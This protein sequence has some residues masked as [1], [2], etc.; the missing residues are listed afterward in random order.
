MESDEN[1][2]FNKLR[3][4][5]MILKEEIAMNDIYRENHN[6]LL[7]KIDKN[8]LDYYKERISIQE[9]YEQ[10]N[11]SSDENHIKFIVTENP[12]KE[13]S[14]CYDP[15][16][17]LMFYFRDSNDLTLKLIDN[18]PKESYD[19]L[20]NFICNY[21]YE[22]IFSS[23]FLN[24]NLLTLI[25]L[26]LEKEID[27]LSNEKQFSTFLDSSTSFTAVLLKHLSRRDEIKLYLENI[28]KKV[29]VRT[30]G[31][32]SNQ[33]NE[34]FI[35]LDINN[36]KNFM[37][38]QKYDLPK[39]ENKI[40][41]L[42]EIL[43]INIKK[44]RLNMNFLKKKTEKEDNKDEELNNEEIKNNFYDE[45]T[46]ETFDELLFENE[47]DEIGMLIDED[48]ESKN[49]KKNFLE[50][51]SSHMKKRVVKDEIENYLINSG[52]Y[53][54]PLVKKQSG[55]VKR[56]EEEELKKKEEKDKLIEKNK[57]KIFS[58]LYCKDLNKETLLSLIKN[59]DNDDME[60]YINNNI[61]N[62]EKGM[63]FTNSNLINEVIN[64][65]GKKAKEISDKIILIYKYHFEV[66]KNLI[67]E[68][69][70]SLVN[71]KEDTPY[72]I[73]AIC[74]IISKLLKIKFPKITNLQKVSLMG[75]ILFTNLIIPILNNPHFNGI[76]IYNFEDKDD[77]QGSSLRST[78]INIITTIIKKILTGELFDGQRKEEENYTIFNPYFIEIMPHVIEFFRNISSTK[79]PINIEDLIEDKKYDVSNSSEGME[80]KENTS[81]D[82]DFNYL[83]A[84]P[85]ERLEHQSMCMSW[86]DYEIIYNIIKSNTSGI[87]G[88]KESIVFKTYKKLT[89]HEATFKKKMEEDEKNSKRTYIYLK[90]LNLD[91]ELNKTIEEK[92]EEKIS[93]QS[94]EIL[95]DSDNEKFILSRIKYCINTII[96][97]LNNLSR[98]NFFVD[99]NESTE[100]IVEGLIRMINLEG[101]ND[102]LKEK[103]FPLEWYGLYLKSN[104]ENIPSEYKDNNYSK[105]YS[106]LLDESSQNLDKIKN[107]Y[108]LNIIYG[109]VINS[110]KKIDIS[111]NNLKRIKNN[112]KNYKILDFILKAEIPVTINLFRNKEKEMIYIEFTKKG[113]KPKYKQ[114]KGE[115]LTKTKCDN[116]VSFCELFP[117]LQK[118]NTE[119]IIKF[120]ENINIK[121]S[122]N[123]YF[124][125]IFNYIN[126]HNSFKEYMDKEEEMIKI[127]LLIEDFIHSQ[128]YDKIYND[129]ATLND[130][131]IF[132][133][134][135]T[136]N[137]IKPT[138][139]NE[140]LIY[141]DEKMTQMMSSF[142]RNIDKEISP[143]NKLRELEKLDLLINNLIMLYG[144]PKDVYLNILTYA[145]I[146]GN[147]FQL[148]SSYNYIK[149]YYSTNFPEKRGID[150]LQKFEKVV[151]KIINF[152]EKD[153]FGISKNVYEENIANFINGI[154]NIK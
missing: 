92:K 39:A 90:K 124:G 71:N 125:I 108:S 98:N 81:K 112:E 105:L 152:S 43:T 106:E 29:L 57:D 132:K 17:K 31:F 86:K 11:A 120:E 135:Y 82:I 128:L 27:K 40:D 22:N 41:N 37:K 115:E 28:L 117:C 144:Y 107:D 47:D 48:S 114:K 9:I 4:L 78:K 110:E 74:T 84:H 8:C 93:F 61:K 33:K 103:S 145:F 153:L 46:K 54:R 55:Y 130:I 63:S 87:V 85:E 13:I 140:N 15:L 30:A 12:E 64:I 96:K 154:K 24:E 99:E 20:A 50:G 70:T 123:E 97:H 116:I 143:N 121:N 89:F 59:Q 76:M 94:N 52:F 26:L 95:S 148:D 16:S 44:S 109:K 100:N 73:R 101:S 7:V 45:A 141:L 62:I 142:I 133:K 146:R 80:N 14:Q 127:R 32:L 136:L 122:L 36:I 38:N 21:F 79:L 149:L 67:D 129:S 131:K 2:S 137:W 119:D 102:I 35:G 83:K 77:K 23:S 25:Y 60:E 138:M 69:F 134:C 42:N 51:T 19:L 118:E 91:D 65:S 5:Q 53:N 88:D 147:P 72:I 111:K 10:K 56:I 113:D 18:C 150:L 126:E 151:E 66:I 58:D 75:E 68:I 104:Y 1:N 139:L 49:Q 34:M 3:K 6:D